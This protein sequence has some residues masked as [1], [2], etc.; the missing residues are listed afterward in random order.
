MPWSSF[1]NTMESLMKNH[2][3]GKDMDGWAKQFTMNYDM[4]IK[5]GGDLINGIK[6]LKGNTTGMESALKGYLKSIQ[7][8][9]STTLL[10]IIGPAIIIYWTG[11]TMS[12]SPPPKI[13]A[14]GAIKN[15]S[16]IVGLVTNPGT[17]SPLPVPANTDS[18]IFITAFKSA[19]TLHLLTVSGT[20]NVLALYPPPPPPGLLLPGVVPWFGYKV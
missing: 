15:Q 20:F 5:T 6:I 16:T 18:K 14:P 8:Q 17:W 9:N 11:A 2:V 19:A 3:Y 4:A 10:D 1:E 13:P 12:L 7:G